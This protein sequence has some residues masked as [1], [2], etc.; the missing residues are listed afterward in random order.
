VLPFEIDGA[1]T[2]DGPSPLVRLHADIEVEN[3]LGKP[4]AST[5]FNVAVMPCELPSSTGRHAR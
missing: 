5:F 3:H 4:S 2:H 1:F